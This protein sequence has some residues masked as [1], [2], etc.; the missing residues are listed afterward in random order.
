MGTNTPFHPPRLAN[1][2]L[3]WLLDDDW[4]T[5]VGDFEEAFHQI[6]KVEDYPRA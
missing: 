3:G 1:W 6:A 2:I 4:E 5:P